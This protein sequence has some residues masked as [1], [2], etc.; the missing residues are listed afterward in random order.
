[1]NPEN[2]AENRNPDGTFKEGISGNP[3]G[4]PKGKTLKEFAREYLMSLPDEEKLEYLKTLPKDIVWKM[5]EGNPKQDTGLT[6]PDGKDLL[7]P[8]LVKFLEN[9]GNN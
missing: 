1:M 6:D 9:G 4:R 7:L 8:V 5:A 3:L 2:Q